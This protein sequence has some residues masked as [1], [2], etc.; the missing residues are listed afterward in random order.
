LKID[1]KI[2]G[3]YRRLLEI[4]EDSLDVMRNYRRLWENID[5]SLSQLLEIIEDY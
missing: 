3:D 1:R 5:G 4:I 2:I